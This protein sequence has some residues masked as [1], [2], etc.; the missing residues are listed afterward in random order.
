[1]RLFIV[2]AQGFQDTCPRSCSYGHASLKLGNVTGR[3]PGDGGHVNLPLI[4]D[5][6]GD[7]QFFSERNF[8]I[9]NKNTGHFDLQKGV[10]AQFFTS[11][12]RLELV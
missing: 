2:D 6:S 1:M 5:Q 10:Y 4:L 11:R 12:N 8:T 3:A 7:S 9:Q